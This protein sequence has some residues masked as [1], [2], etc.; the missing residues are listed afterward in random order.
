MQNYVLFHVDHVVENIKCSYSTV[1]NTVDK[2]LSRK[3]RKLFVVEKVSLD[4]VTIILQHNHQTSMCTVLFG[5]K[6][7]DKQFYRITILSK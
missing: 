2:V 7:N 6:G 5:S 4:T 1:L 3:Y